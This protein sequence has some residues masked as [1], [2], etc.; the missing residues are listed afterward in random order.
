MLFWLILT[1][2]PAMGV[3]R[4][5]AL[6]RY[7]K[8]EINNEQLLDLIFQLLKHQPTLKGFVMKLIEKTYGDVGM[9]SKIKQIDFRN[10][11]NNL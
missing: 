8:N 2:F 10:A 11:K 7:K 1:F 9:A 3:I 6:K 4:Q 5:T